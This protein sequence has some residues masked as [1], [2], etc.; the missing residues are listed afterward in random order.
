[1]PINIYTDDDDSTKVAYLCESSWSLPT[2][3]SELEKWI[4]LNKQN[5]EKK[6]Y[7]ADIGF[8]IREDASGGGATMSPMLMG[9]L[10]ESGFSLYLSEYRGVE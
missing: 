8:A 5:L 2:Q 9:V 4:L 7:V 10:S 1:M 6:L 3:I